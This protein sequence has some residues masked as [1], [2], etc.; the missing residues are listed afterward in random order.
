MLKNR[1][2]ELAIGLL[3]KGAKKLEEPQVP[4]P[5]E[6]Q[7]AVLK[8]VVIPVEEHLVRTEVAAQLEASFAA[9]VWMDRAEEDQK[10]FVTRVYPVHIVEAN[11]Y[12][13]MVGIGRVESQMEETAVPLHQFLQAFIPVDQIKFEEFQ[14]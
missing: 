9:I 3:E 2:I 11:T 6:I 7:E 5:V 13:C 12:T 8:T 14:A 1:I 10:V 4:A